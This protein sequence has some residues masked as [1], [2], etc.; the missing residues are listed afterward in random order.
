MYNDIF[1]IGPVTIHGYG[2]M[3]AIGILAAFFYSERQ[4]KKKGM[5][6]DQVDSMIFFILILGFLCAKI[7]YLITIFPSFISSPL[8]YIGNS[9]FVVYGGILGGILGCWIFCQRKGWVFKDVLNM[10]MP[11]VSLGQGF[12]RIGCFLAGCCYGKET[13]S[14]IGVTFPEGSLAPAGVSLLP[15]QLFSSLGNFIIFAIIYHIYT[16]GKHP[17][18]T[19]GWYLILYSLGRFV[20]EFFRGDT[21]RGFVGPFSTSQCIAIV[22]FLAGAYLIYRRQ[23]KGELSV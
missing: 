10:L 11:A 20:I 14:W 4:G 21:I 2:V 13:S 16:K 3:I 17:E 7:L 12:G 19:A 6:T 1:S 15:T 9:G 22:T 8:D 23:K 5:D 18:D